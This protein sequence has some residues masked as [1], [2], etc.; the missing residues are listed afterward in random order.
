LLNPDYHLVVAFPTLC[1]VY[2]I[3]V[4]IP[5]SSA[6]K[7]VYKLV[8]LCLKKD[9]KR[10]YLWPLNRRLYQCFWTRSWLLPSFG[11]LT[12]FLEMPEI[13][14]RYWISIIFFGFWSNM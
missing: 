1:K 11:G 6:L 8:R 5:I 2:A 13:D 10:C 12:Y 4:A 3:P 14:N 7:R 9:L